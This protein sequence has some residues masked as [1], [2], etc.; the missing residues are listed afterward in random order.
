MTNKHISN[1]SCNEYEFNKAK[2]L[3]ESALESRG[4][5]YSMKFEA[6]VEKAKRNR[7]RKIIWFNL[8]YSLNV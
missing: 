3:D 5:N 4:F 1:L 6:P 7:N 2:P 8:S